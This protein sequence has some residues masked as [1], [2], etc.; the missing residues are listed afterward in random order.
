M[1]KYLIL[2]FIAFVTLSVN[3]QDKEKTYKVLASCG[4]CNFG[5]E[6]ESGCRLAIQIAGKHYWVNGSKLQDHGDEH[7]ED[8]MCKTTKK[9]KVIGVLKDDT[10]TCSSFELIDKRKPT[11]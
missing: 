7:A 10:I 9:A 1:K 5:M 4:T 6:N 2:L 8:G 11:K 3:A